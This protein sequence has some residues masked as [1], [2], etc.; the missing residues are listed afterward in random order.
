MMAV[1]DG[2]GVF[3]RPWEGGQSYFL[4]AHLLTFIFFSSKGALILVFGS[5]TRSFNSVSSGLEIKGVI[6]CY[7]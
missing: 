2:L 1:P 5:T 7:M 3:G 4:S 6:L